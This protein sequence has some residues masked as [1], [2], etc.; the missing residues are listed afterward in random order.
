LTPSFVSA[1]IVEQP[2]EIINTT[3][4]AAAKDGQNFSSSLFIG[5]LRLVEF[6]SLC[7][8]GNNATAPIDPFHFLQQT[9]LI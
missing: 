3:A 5:N 6:L 8:Q 7:L 2:A 9:W 4:K 1:A